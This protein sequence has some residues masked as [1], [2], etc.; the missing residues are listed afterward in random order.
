MA[1][2]DTAGKDNKQETIVSYRKESDNTYTK[3]IKYILRDHK[4]GM[5]SSSKLKTEETGPYVLVKEACDFDEKM[6]FMDID[7]T[8]KFMY[9]KKITTPEIE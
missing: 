8:E 1:R 3:L 6:S 5:T 9:F 7:G 2:I 4:T